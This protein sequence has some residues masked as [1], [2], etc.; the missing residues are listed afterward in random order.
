MGKAQPL[1]RVGL[2][3]RAD[4]RHGWILYVFALPYLA[5][6]FSPG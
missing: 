1:G 5:F 4:G 6:Q 2:R 3:P